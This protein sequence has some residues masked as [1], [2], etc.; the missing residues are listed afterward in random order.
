M[1]REGKKQKQDTREGE[2]EVQAIQEG[3]TQLE[4][5]SRSMEKEHTIWRMAK[6]HSKQH[7]GDIKM[8]SSTR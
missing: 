3:R 8:L 5:D 6:G 4:C 7:Q 1:E 2:T